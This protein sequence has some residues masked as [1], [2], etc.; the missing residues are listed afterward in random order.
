MNMKACYTEAD[1][2][3]D[4]QE[5]HLSSIRGSQIKLPRSPANREVH[6]KNQLISHDFLDNDQPVVKL[7]NPHITPA[8]NSL[9][10]LGFSG[11]AN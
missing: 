8:P 5:E 3:Y 7:L 11:S 9:N 1:R 2:Y 10:T 6:H 4:G